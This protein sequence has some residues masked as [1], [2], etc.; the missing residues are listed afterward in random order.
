MGKKKSVVLMILLTIVIVVL[1]CLT[2]FPSFSIPETV[3]EWNP[4]I[5][6]YDLGADL[7]GSYYA[8]YYPE[9]V[10]T[11]AEYEELDAEE[12]KDYLQNG[13]LYLS[14][15]P[16]YNLV[17]AGEVMEDFKTE[18]AKAVEVISARY[19]AKGYSDYSVSV[20][21]DY[22]LKIELP[23]S[24]ANV[25]TVLTY[26]SYTQKMTLVMGGDT[27]EEL[28]GKE[29]KISD[30]IKGFSV[31]TRYNVAYIKVKF[32]KAGAEMLDRVK[33]TL[34]TSETASTTTDASALKTLDIKMGD[35]DTAIL[36]ILKDYVDGNSAIIPVA[37][38][39]EIATAKTL[40]VLLNSALNADFEVDFKDVNTNEIRIT[41]S[42]YGEKVL[43]WVYVALGLA[44]LGLIVYAIVKMGRYGVVGMYTSLSYLIVVGICYAFISGGVFEITL[45]SLLVFLAGLVM[46]NVL[47][48]R[49]YN[50]I[51]NEYDLGKT[52]ASSVKQGYN[53][54]IM[55]MVDV[56]AVLL[57]GALAFLIGAAGLYT[58]AL[59]AIICIVT[60]AFCNL[61]W[62]RA[63]NYVFLSAS[64]NK[65]K[66]FRFEVKE[67]DDDEY[68]EI[69]KK[70]YAPFR[71]S[72]NCSRGGVCG[73]YLVRYEW[74]HRHQRYED[75][76]GRR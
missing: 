55:G 76:D 46:I 21:D 58:L 72:G 14:K 7:G 31:T 1:S 51:K 52:V 66:Y 18:F 24:E 74:E 40:N 9:G 60:G 37:Y 45:G 20:I 30:L 22:A 39:E 2:V 61:L 38:T 63:I 59:Q 43:V 16:S 35:S 73:W 64:K 42:A 65:N 67:D 23:K 11:E 69:C 27:V 29:T 6:Q 13:S 41:E 68:G 32:T 26:F 49:T 36:Q 19:A 12:Q 15:D 56:Y 34:S 8:Y 50:A 3:K 33:D 57:L 28:K 17:S 10:I 4:S 53:K 75:V 71:S 62:G 54:T 47:N 48:A 25:A 5:M 44:M 70:R